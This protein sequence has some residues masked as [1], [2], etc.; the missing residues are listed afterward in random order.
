MPE[1]AGTKFTSNKVKNLVEF[2]ITVGGNPTRKLSPPRKLLESS[3]INVQRLKAGF[4]V[5]SHSTNIV[6]R[7]LFNE[8]LLE[9]IFRGH[10]TKYKC[11]ENFVLYGI[12]YT[13][14]Y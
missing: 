6:Q 11:L 4:R 5:S 3:A 12:R 7:T 2:M 13:A 9:A 14:L 1:Y 10:S 8:M